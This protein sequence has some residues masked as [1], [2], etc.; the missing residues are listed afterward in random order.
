MPVRFIISVWILLPILS[1]S[2][3]SQG[4]APYPNAVTDR[5]VHAKTPMAPPSVRAPFH[6][7]DFGSM[8]VR[9]TDE[10]TDARFP[11]S[12]FRNPTPDVNE[13]SVDNRKFYVSEG[14]GINHINIAFAFDSSTMTVSSLPGAS[15]NGG[16]QVPLRLGPTFSFLDSDLMYGTDLRQPLTI[17]AF[18]FSTGKTSPLID[19]TTCGTQPALVAGK[20]V[21]SGDLTVSSDDS[22]IVI[23]AGGNSASKRPFVIVYDQKLGCRWYNTQ[24]GQIGGTWGDIGQASTPD[25]FVV[26]H[27]KISGNGQYV[28]IGVGNTGFY[29]WDLSTQNVTACKVHGTLKCSGYGAIGYDSYINTPGAIDEL[30]TL[31]RNLGDL[32]V[33]TPLINP[34]PLPHYKGMEKLFAWSNGRVNTNAPVCGATY[35]PS[36]NTEIKQPYDGEIFCMETDGLASTIWRFA[37][38]RAVWDPEYYW[39]EP[40]GNMSLDGRFYIFTSGWDNQVGTTADGD[41][42]TDIWII[43]LD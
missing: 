41:P 11:G 40:A 21:S 24:T 13:W 30:N 22:R 20:K 18:R 43:K 25:R 3:W 12:F 16:L 10:K 7:P 37:H 26:N 34:L 32:S 8:M 27:S 31:R 14:N 2:L 35:S 1:L 39:T 19:V 4:I 5:V 15:P 29:I 33:L 28:R 6:E 9:V 36:G 38:N 42:R 17:D 23:S